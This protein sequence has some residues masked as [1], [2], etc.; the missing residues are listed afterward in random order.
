MLLFTHQF[1]RLIRLRARAA[2][3]LVGDAVADAVVRGDAVLRELAAA[4]A[5]RHQ[6]G[7]RRLPLR[8]L[9]LLAETRNNPRTGIHVC[10]CTNV[11]AH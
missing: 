5:A 2:R 6:V 8:L 11:L 4:V 7:L 10:I 3:T 9:H 1:G